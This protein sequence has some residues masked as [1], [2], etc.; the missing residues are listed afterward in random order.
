MLIFFPWLTVASSRP[1]QNETIIFIRHAEKVYPNNGNL[2]CQ[3]LNRSLKLPGVIRSLFGKIDYFYA[4][5]PQAFCSSQ[6]PYVRALATIE[7]LAISQSFPVNTSY[8]CDDYEGVAQELLLNPKFESKKI[9]LAWEHVNLVKIIQAMDI[10]EVPDWK[11]GDYDTIMVVTITNGQKQL[12][13]TSEGLNGQSNACPDGG[14][15]SHT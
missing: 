10:K 7:P 3:G 2:D 12:K 5:N 9:L 11:W 15:I 1:N 6:Y 8:A 14:H 13:I 4:P